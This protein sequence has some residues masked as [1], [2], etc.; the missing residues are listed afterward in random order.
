[1][2]F[3]F[4]SIYF[5]T[6]LFRPHFDTSLAI[7]FHDSTTLTVRIS[8]VSVKAQVGHVSGA[9]SVGSSFEVPTKEIELFP[10][11]DYFFLGV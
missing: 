11:L 5:L 2:F 9:E 8:E 1:M 10:Y 4:V 3:R 6:N 7:S